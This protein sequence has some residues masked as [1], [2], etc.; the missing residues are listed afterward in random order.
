MDQPF[1]EVCFCMAPSISLGAFSLVFYMYDLKHDM[2]FTIS[3]NI[4]N[5][6]MGSILDKE[7]VFFYVYRISTLSTMTTA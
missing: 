3:E 7:R 4:L 5:G 1:Q 2:I 6:Q